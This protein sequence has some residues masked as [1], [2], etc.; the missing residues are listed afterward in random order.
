MFSDRF[1]IPS[2]TS[3]DT[4]TMVNLVDRKKEVNCAVVRNMLV[5]GKKFFFLAIEKKSEMFL[6]SS[7]I[8]I[9]IYKN[10]RR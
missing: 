3:T 7:K 4:L 1:S 2:D 8:F 10:S 5:T 6:S 9:L